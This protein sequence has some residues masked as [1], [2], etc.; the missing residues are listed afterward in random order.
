MNDQK[1]NS[2]AQRPAAS[3]WMRRLVFGGLLLVLPA[4]GV[5]TA[6]GIVPGTAP[7]EVDR[8]PVIREIALPQWNADEKDSGRYVTQERVLRG[9][10]VAALLDRLGAHEIEGLRILPAEAL[11]Q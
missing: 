11:Q 2:L 3:T 8:T 4:L 5:V 6:F 9:D 1:G 7:E 10:T